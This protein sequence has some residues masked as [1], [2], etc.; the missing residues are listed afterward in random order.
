MA[1][2]QSRCWLPVASPLHTKWEC[3]KARLF[4]LEFDH[5]DFNGKGKLIHAAV[6]YEA[7]FVSGMFEGKGNWYLLMA[8]SMAWENLHSPSR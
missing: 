8:R 3:S 4:L 2:G 7:D 5:V 1:K 6:Q